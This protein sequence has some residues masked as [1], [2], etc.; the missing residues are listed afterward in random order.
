MT[1]IKLATVATADAVQ[2]E[3]C[4]GAKDIL[5]IDTEY[6]VFVQDLAKR[7]DAKTFSNQS[8]SHALTILHNV[9]DSAE[10]YVDIFSG[11]LDPAVYDNEKLLD[12]VKNFIEKRGGKVNV[13]LQEEVCEARLSDSNNF[14]G[15]ILANSDNGCSIQVVTQNN[16]LAKA[17]KHFLVADDRIYRVELDIVKHTAVCSFQESSIAINLRALFD[18]CV[19]PPHTKKLIALANPL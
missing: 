6:E 18:I 10:K 12:S 19:M 2:T 8:R 5:E 13:L 3:N 15:T 4:L 7:K 16:N 17:D 14:I 1:P 9:F 11:N